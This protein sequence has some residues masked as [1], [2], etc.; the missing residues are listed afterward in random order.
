MNENPHNPKSPNA[1]SQ[2]LTLSEAAQRTPGRPSVSA[3]WRWARRGLVGR[4]GARV[5][6]KHIRLGSRLLTTE[7]WL[8]DFGHALAAE[9]AA[10]FGQRAVHCRSQ[11]PPKGPGA[12]YDEVTE[13]ETE[14]DRERRCE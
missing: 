4:S 1:R 14:L 6:L 5:F 13:A 12:S 2:Y 3:L 8:L 9:D 7:R 10:H 11:E